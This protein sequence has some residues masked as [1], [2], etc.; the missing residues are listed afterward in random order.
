MEG[1]ETFV[2]KFLYFPTTGHSKEY[3]H[4]FFYGNFDG[5]IIYR[6]V[7]MDEK[8]LIL[9]VQ[10]EP[11]LYDPKMSGYLDKLLRENTWKRIGFETN[12]TVSHKNMYF[13]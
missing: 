1:V 8:K 2:G 10:K 6:A 3:F 7:D 9:A 4:N 13:L 11:H 12:M 5:V